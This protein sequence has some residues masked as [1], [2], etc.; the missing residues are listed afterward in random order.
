MK[1]TTKINGIELDLRGIEIN[2]DR[3]SCED[4][5]V[6]VGSDN[7]YD[8]RLTEIISVLRDIFR[9]VFRKEY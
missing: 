2:I 7:A 3:I 1:R 5:K 9:N 6:T 8:S 4:F